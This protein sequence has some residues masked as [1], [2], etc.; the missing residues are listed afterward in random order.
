MRRTAVSVMGI[1]VVILFLTTNA[2]AISSPNLNEYRPK[3]GEG[4]IEYDGYTYLYRD[5]DSDP[6]NIEYSVNV[7]F[8]RD[9]VYSM[10]SETSMKVVSTVYFSVLQAYQKRYGTTYHADSYGIKYYNDAMEEVG[11]GSSSAEVTVRINTETGEK[12]Q[13]LTPYGAS[14]LLVGGYFEV[15]YVYSF[16]GAPFSL[17][18]MESESDDI[19]TS[20]TE[21]DVGYELGN[22]YVITEEG[23]F[24]NRPVWILEQSSTPEGY[25]AYS[26]TII[27]DKTTGL[28]LKQEIIA[29]YQDGSQYRFK[30]VA[31]DLGDVLPE[32]ASTGNSL[33][34]VAGIGG[35][36]GVI[37]I[38]LLVW[39]MKSRQKETWQFG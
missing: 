15:I 7:S 27:V 38:V 34:V 16:I 10:P 29:E 2:L 36:G 35:L 25:A 9:E 39:W 31:T 3:Y 5:P 28:F 33:L 8:T 6:N 26:V 20:F 17:P 37:V 24:L 13:V 12:I 4:T 30:G 19:F 21:W 1:V 32:P 23:M 18:K 11:T 14:L 22:Q